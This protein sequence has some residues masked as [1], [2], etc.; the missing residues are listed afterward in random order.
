MTFLADQRRIRV[1]AWSFAGFTVLV[2]TAAIVLLVLDAR[3]VGASR[4][5]TY[6]FAGAGCLVYA[7]IGGLLAARMPRNAIGW[8]LGLTGFWLAANMFV[9]QYGLR[10]L[11]AAPGSLPAV[12]A[13]AAL[14]QAANNLIFV[15]LILVVLLFPTGR[16]PSKRWRPVLWATLWVLVVGGAAQTLQRGTVVSGGLTN[17]LQTAHVEYPNPLGVFP[18]YGWYDQLLAVTAAMAGACALLAIVSVFVRR[19]GASAELRQQLAWLGYVGALFLITAVVTITY[20]AVTHGGNTPL[21]TLLFV[22]LFGIPL[23]GIPAASAVAVLRYHLYD[24]DIV[25]RKTVVAALVAAAFTAIYALIVLGVGAAAGH[26]GSSVLTFAAAALA[27]VLL[28]PLRVRAGRLADRLVYGRR[29]TP[30]EVLSEFSERVAGTYSTDQVLP[31]MARMLAG[32]T[33]AQRTEVWMQVGGQARREATW[34]T[35]SLDGEPAPEPAGADVGGPGERGDRTREFA[36][37]HYGE[38]LGWLRLT[39]GPREPLTP[40]GERLARD[41]AAQA[42]LV[43]RNVAL[44]EDLRASRQRIVAAADQARRR[45]ERDLHDGAQQQLVA[46]RISLGLARSAVR[47]APEEA[48][49]LLEQTEQAASRA[50]EDLR[51]LA[52]GIYPPLLAD[53][54]LRAALE[55]QARKAALP[56]TVEAPA[57]G[58]YPQPTEAAL[59]FSVLEALQN[60]AKYARASAARVTLVQDGPSVVFTVEDDGTGFDPATTP[61]GTG[62]QGIADRLA[63][64]GGTVEVTSAPGRGTRVTGQV[65]AAGDDSSPPLEAVSRGAAPF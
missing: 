25:V 19:R 28:Q 21:G 16:L 49:E 48:G 60:V 10:G 18:R 39:S 64:L 6:A 30:Y 31:A 61:M 53:L 43:L 57:V 45:I 26:R 63:A 8:L 56:V 7:G 29:A 1:V 12:R 35:D 32:A 58:R 44:I 47:T 3:V 38:R 13:V 11:A 22:L 41:V 20:I 62:L 33:G 4:I 34:P 40:A 2:L 54:G 50:L 42:G 23:L 36:V 52:R 59:Y 37:E 65:P 17:A 15:T 27:A 14:G 46:L 55:A 24:L 9:E 51:D 5:G